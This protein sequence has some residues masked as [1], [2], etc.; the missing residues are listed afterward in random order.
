MARAAMRKDLDNLKH[1]A[2][3]CL[4][5]GDRRSCIRSMENMALSGRSTAHH[6]PR[7]VWS[8]ERMACDDN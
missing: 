7:A 1:C 8:A 2:E 3:N 6:I 4:A 5:E